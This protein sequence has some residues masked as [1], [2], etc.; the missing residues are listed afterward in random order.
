MLFVTTAPR[1]LVHR[2][3]GLVNRLT[4]CLHHR[5]NF[6]LSAVAVSVNGTDISERSRKVL[7]LVVQAVQDLA[8]SN[9]SQEFFFFFSFFSESWSSRS[10][11]T[12]RTVPGNSI[13]NILTLNVLRSDPS[14]SS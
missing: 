2:P 9:C 4:Y 6:S 5:Q 11:A 1:S 10:V 3:V 7:G 8:A 14:R 12:P 13:P